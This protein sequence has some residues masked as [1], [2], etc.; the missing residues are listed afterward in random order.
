M[1]LED[2]SR[3][4]K[5]ARIDALTKD[6]LP[7]H[8]DGFAIGIHRLFKEAEKL[9][10]GE[11][12]ALHVLMPD[13][14]LTRLYANGDELLYGDAIRAL[15]HTN[16]RLRVLEV[17]AGTGGTT[18]KVLDALTTSTGQR[19]YSAYTYTDIS[20][21]F[22]SAAKERFGAFEGIEYKTFDVTKDPAEQQLQKGSYDLVIGYNV[23][24]LSVHVFH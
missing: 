9:F 4:Q 7:S 23:C 19:L 17:G 14:V 24:Y 8:Y 2:L 21:G 1:R 11:T 18:S 10:S 13:D 12:H 15:G 16:P 22:F 6:L 3:E 20:A 5:I